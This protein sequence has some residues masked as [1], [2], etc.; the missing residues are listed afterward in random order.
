MQICK[1]EGENMSQRGSHPFLFFSVLDFTGP[2]LYVFYDKYSV[3]MNQRL[4][5]SYW[6]NHELAF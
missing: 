1:A 4:C 5:S 6:E 2:F 3:E